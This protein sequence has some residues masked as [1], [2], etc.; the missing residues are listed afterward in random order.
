MA[1][2]AVNVGVAE[3]VE[4]RVTEVP[5]SWDQAYVRESPS[6]SLDPEA[7]S[8]TVA[9]SAG[10]WSEPALAE[11]ASFTFTTVRTY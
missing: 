2:G 7:S 8:V 5:L 6:S 9:P 10:V 3:L 1:S 4:D 11:G